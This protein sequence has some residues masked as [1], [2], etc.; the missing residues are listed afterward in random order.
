MLRRREGRVEVG[1]GKKYFSDL[2]CGFEV[3]DIVSGEQDG[4]C[5]S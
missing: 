4:D 1:N 2:R 5:S 3:L